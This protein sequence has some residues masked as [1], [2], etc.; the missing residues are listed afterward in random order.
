MLLA[1]VTVLGVVLL[2]SA[3]NVRYR[4]VPYVIPVFMQVM[5]LLSGVPYALT[6]VP[7]KWQWIL[8]LNPMTTVIAGWRWAVLGNAAP[9]PAQAA[10]SVAVA[11]RAARVRLH[12]LPLRRAAV[13][14]PDLMSDP[15]VSVE[16]VAKRYRLGELHATYGTLRDSL[17]SAVRRHGRH[18]NQKHEEIWALDDV[19]FELRR[20]EVLGLIGGNGAGKSTLLKVLTRIAAP[21]SGSARDPRAGREPARGRH[22]L[23]P[24]AHRPRERLPQRRHPRDEAPGDHGA[25]RRDRR[26]LRASR[27]SST[28]RSSATRAACTCGSPS[29]SPRTSSPRSCSSTRCS[30]SATPSSS[31]AASAGWR[32]LGES[33]RTVIFVSHNM[34][35]VAQLCD[36]AVLLDRGKVVKDGDSAEV[37]AHYLQSGL[38]SGSERVWPDP[39][40]APGDDLV[41]LTDARVVG[42]DGAPLDAVDVRRPVGIEIGF[43]VLRADGQPVRPKFKLVDRRGD[44]AFNAWDIDPRW[45]VSAAP[46]A[47]VTTAWIPG[48][49]LNEG[50]YSADIAVCSVHAP[51]LVHHFQER[52]ALAFHVQDPGL[53][54]S[55][56]GP[57]TG[58]WRGVVRPLLQWTVEARTEG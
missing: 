52:S 56:R 47:Y 24:R 49:L 30:R 12:L 1:L 15:V 23:P 37:V 29:R 21:T 39:E 48:N 6:S 20:G 34:Q 5:P 54:D 58:Q 3:V 14:R 17:M 22:G 10:L 31:G 53:G 2:L 36:R 27:S 43:R 7:E 38:G 11:R 33:G 51:R 25:V 28:R 9:V 19:S 8:A 41:R 18:R 55:A 46:G 16:D 57:Y 26:V 45:D 50:L 4:D 40:S 13:R 42:E 32:S 44:I 35:T